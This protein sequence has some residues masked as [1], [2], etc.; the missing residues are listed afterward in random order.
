[1]SP[2]ILF[3]FFIR[4]GIVK[5]CYCFPL[6]CSLSSS[7]K[8]P[9]LAVHYIQC[10][11]QWSN[12]L[13]L[14]TES[15]CCS[16]SSLCCSICFLYSFFLLLVCSLSCLFCS[17]LR[18]SQVSAALC[19]ASSA[20]CTV[21]FVCFVPRLLNFLPR[22]QLSCLYLLS[23]DGLFSLCCSLSCLFCFP[24]SLFCSLSL[25]TSTLSCLF[26]CCPA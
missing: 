13:L 25:L 18:V 9:L 7:E 4:F 12:P 24:Y 21:L 14:C 16:P 23:A 22:L 19:P 3:C 11:T 1:M 15:L 6:P 5:K 2:R 17:A 10:P 20:F 8:P 26:C